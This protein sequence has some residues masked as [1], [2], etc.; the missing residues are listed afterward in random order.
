MKNKKLPIGVQTFGEIRNN[1]YCYADKTNFIEQLVEEGKYYFISR[2]RRFGKSLFLD[3]L[4]C[5]FSNKKEL[6]NNLY[7]TS[8]Q[9]K[10]DWKQTNPVVRISLGSRI[11]KTIKELREH[12]NR[13]IEEAANRHNLKLTPEESPSFKMANLVQSLHQ[14]TGSPAVVLIDEYDK[15]ILDNIEDKIKASQ[16]QEELKSFY[17]VFKDLDAH[18]KLLFLTGVSKFSKTGIFS[19]LNNLNDITL[20]KRYSA[21]CGYQE[22]DL[23]IAFAEWTKKLDRKKIRTWYNGYSWGGDTV[24][25]PFDILLFLSNNEYRSYWFETGTPTFLMKLWKKQPRLPADYDGMIVNENLLSNFDINNLQPET[26]LFQTGYL[27][28]KEKMEVGS[29]LNYRIGFPNLEVRSAFNQRLLSEIT[30]PKNTTELGYQLANSLLNNNKKQLK[31]VF[32]ALLSSIP[33]DWHRKNNIAKYEGYWATII[34]CF[35][36]SLGYETIPEDTTNKGR[37]DLTLITNEAIWIFEFKVTEIDKS[38]N[39]SPLQQ[40]NEKNYTDKYKHRG[41]T[42]HKIGIIFNSNKREISSWETETI[43]SK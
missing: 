1:N 2:P 27:T 26:I 43:N 16:L 12:L 15:P 38:G 37:I 13:Q 18:L 17:S 19:G 8:K 25:N 10:W 20:N 39:K 9:S 32:T 33:H 36:A 23:N 28:I 11:N 3:T 35:L 31:K 34:Y 42:I 5:A 40:I 24:Y 7:L 22:H 21:L 14:N 6:F 30:S 4:D 29:I 41:K